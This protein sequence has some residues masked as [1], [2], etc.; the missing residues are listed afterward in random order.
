MKEK[1]KRIECVCIYKLTSELIKRK[2][3]I[4]FIYL[5]E[6]IEIIYYTMYIF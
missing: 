4:F 1:K 5:L 2:K 6:V 3:K